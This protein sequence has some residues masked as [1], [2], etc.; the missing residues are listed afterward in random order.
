[1]PD[2]HVI[3]RPRL[4]ELLATRWTHRVVTVIAGPGFG[5]ST[6]LAQVDAENAAARR[7]ASVECR[8]ID[9]ASPGTVR[10]VVSKAPASVHFVLASRRRLPGLSRLRAAGQLAEI[11]E[12][13][14]ALTDAESLAL[15]DAYVADPAV[16]ASAAGWPGAAA[17]AA[18]YGPDA[19]A[20][21]ARDVVLNHLTE[22]ER[23][24]LAVAVT[25]GPEL[26]PLAIDDATGVL[27]RVP[28]VGRA[29][30]WSPLVGGD[31]DAEERRTLVGRVVSALIDH[32]DHERAFGLCEATQ[33]W[34]RAATVVTATCRRGHADVRSDVLRRW[35]DAWPEDRRDEPTGLLLAGLVGRIEDPFASQTADRLAAAVDGYRAAGNIAGEVTA[36]TELAYVLRNQGRLETLPPLLLRAAELHAAGHREAEGPMALSR[37]LMAE[38][39]GDD[40]QLVAELEAVPTGSLSRDWRAV[41]AFRETLARLAL[42][43][44]HETLAAAERCAALAGS[45][46]SRHALPLA[47]WFAGDAGPALQDCDEIVRDAGRSRVDAVALGAFAT[48]VL[49]TAGRTG[50][51]EAQLAVTERAAHGPLSTT[52]RGFVSGV[53]ALVAI[54]AADEQSA[55]AVVEEA[56]P[57]GWRSARLWL[58]LAYVLLPTQRD[59][60]ASAAIGPVHQ[61]R[62]A[63]ARAVAAAREGRAPDTAELTCGTVVTTVP[64][65]WAMTLAARL[66][67]DGQPLG[68]EIVA[69]AFDLFGEP[70]KAALRAAADSSDRRVATGARRLLAATSIA[71]RHPVRLDVLGPAVLR[72]EGTECADADWQRERVRSLL[73]YLVAC[74]PSRREQ[75]TDALWPDLE[76][77]AAD[78]NLRVTLS[79]LQR[80]I[81]PDRRRGEAPFLLGQSGPTLSLAPAPHFVVDAW[82]FEALLDQADEADH[83]G[84]PNRAL[85]LLEQAVALWRGPC[86]ADAAYE[87]WAQVTVRHLTE[88]FV[89]ASVRAAE[90]NLALGRSSAARRLGRR[91]LAADEWCEPAHRVLIAAAL[92]DGDHAGAVRAL[93]DCDAMLTHL[94]AAPDAE[95]RK[96]RDRVRGSLATAV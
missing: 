42:G 15:A 61:R 53:R 35:F 79:Y 50:A 82:D 1:M 88:R 47:T 37:A 48:M 32:E 36:G 20:E 25:V 89:S 81:E 34:D 67:A 4:A 59:A 19:I 94:G 87:D 57:D 92:A 90:L 10:E 12:R 49:A 84:L 46:T 69:A 83:R 76:T 74:G 39:S 72:I 63:V 70:A 65:A 6:L 40:H 9:D 62:L 86:F 58:P 3:D 71:P 2:H 23:K 51:A 11:G 78:R 30:F 64:V 17:V 75:L 93:D 14:L 26:A 80:V 27:A 13:E 41:I 38:L 24:V 31:I 91:A 85:E 66:T 96:L 28:L 68:G 18:A 54:S 7:H 55:R 77:E 21:Y 73:L 95:T 52:L 33:D 22:D 43:Q 44:D 5:K 16:V 56:L 8:I 29:D 45:A 60:I